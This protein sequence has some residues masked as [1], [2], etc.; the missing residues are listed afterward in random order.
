VKTARI[1]VHIGS[2]YAGSRRWV[3]FT[4]ANGQPTSL[5][6]DECDMDRDLMLA[7]ILATNGGE[8]ALRLP[9]AGLVGEWVAV[10]PQTSI[11]A[12]GPQT[13]FIL[14][15]VAAVLGFVVAMALLMLWAGA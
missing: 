5:V 6:V 9:R 13:A 10:V 11:I 1:R 4:A 14:L 2:A 7:G 12:E 15:L 8:V 3:T